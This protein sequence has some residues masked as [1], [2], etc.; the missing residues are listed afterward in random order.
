MKAVFYV[1]LIILVLFIFFIPC[2]LISIYIHH[3]NNVSTS[4]QTSDDCSNGE[5][6]ISGQCVQNNNM[7]SCQTT[8]D[9]PGGYTC[10]NNICMEVVKC[11]NDASCNGFYCNTITSQC[12]T[13]SQTIQV[14][15][16]FAWIPDSNLNN[17]VYLA[18]WNFEPG[19]VAVVSANNQQ[20]VIIQSN[21]IYITVNLTY[22]QISPTAKL[23]M[24]KNRSNNYPFSSLLLNQNPQSFTATFVLDNT[25]QSSNNLNLYKFVVMDNLN[26]IIF[27]QVNSLT[28]TLQPFDQ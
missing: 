1:G 13:L 6:C 21:Y 7:Q 4:C 25:D 9:C 3:K 14:F 12:D 20:F 2:I 16:N 22:A 19:Q 17:P 11:T 23:I 28:L 15:Y 8:P 26:N 27:D 18:L 24:I 5:L 10:T